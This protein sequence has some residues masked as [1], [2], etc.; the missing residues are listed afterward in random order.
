[1]TMYEQ[2]TLW[3]V[4]GVG[5]HIPWANIYHGPTYTMGQGGTGRFPTEHVMQSIGNRSL[6][7]QA[8]AMVIL[9]MTITM[10]PCLLLQLAHRARLPNGSCRQ[11]KCDFTWP[12]EA[13]GVGL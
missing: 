5:P 4:H 1:M 12:S 9:H 8:E 2:V 10:S 7:E 3:Q 13:G 6:H 11:V